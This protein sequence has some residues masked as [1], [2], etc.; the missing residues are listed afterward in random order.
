MAHLL[1]ADG[2]CVSAYIDVSMPKGVTVVDL[3]GSWMTP[4]EITKRTAPHKAHEGET[5]LE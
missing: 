1:P 4:S 3:Y 5:R 2:N